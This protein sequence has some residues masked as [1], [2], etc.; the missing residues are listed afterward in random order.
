MREIEIKARVHDKDVLMLAFSSIG[1]ELSPVKKQHDIVYSLPGAVDNEPGANWLRVRVENDKKVIFTLKRSVTGELDSIEHE[2]VVDSGTEIKSIIKYLGYKLFSDLTKYRQK[3][4]LGDVEICFDEVPGLGTFIEVE[5]LTE[6]DA[7][8]DAVA[9]DLWSVL[10]RLN[11]A[12]EDEET[13]GYDVLMRQLETNTS[14][15]VSLDEKE[16]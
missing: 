4:K 13:S 2:V 7:D 16:K 12:P 1:V 8:Y 11:V 5:K 10:N 14:T 6:E 15:E 3:A 9:K